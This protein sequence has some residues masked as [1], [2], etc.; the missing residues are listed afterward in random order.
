MKKAADLAFKQKE[1]IKDILETIE[2]G[3]FHFEYKAD[4]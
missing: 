1:F 2:N 3:Y 4:N